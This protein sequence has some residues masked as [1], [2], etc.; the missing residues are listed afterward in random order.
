MFAIYPIGKRMWVSDTFCVPG[1]LQA[2]RMSAI[3]SVT[4]TNLRNIESPLF[5]ALPTSIG[6]IVSGMTRDSEECR[7]STYLIYCAFGSA[8]RDGSCHFKNLF[9]SKVT[10]PYNIKARAINVNT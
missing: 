2:E 10:I 8:Q 5:C 3:P 4:K 9:S 1:L 7:R 6:T